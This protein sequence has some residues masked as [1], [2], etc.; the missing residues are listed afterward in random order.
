MM[1]MMTVITRMTTIMMSP[2]MKRI[3]IKKNNYGNSDSNGAERR[4]IPKRDGNSLS[5]R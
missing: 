3:I 5:N 1:T 2:L 4:I